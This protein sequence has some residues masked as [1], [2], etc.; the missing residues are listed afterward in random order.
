MSSNGLPKRRVVTR[1]A[2]RKGWRPLVAMALLLLPLVSASGLWAA[3]TH[4]DVIVRDI[5]SRV[6]KLKEADPETVPM[7][8][9]DFDGTIIKGD[10]SEGLVEDGVVRYRGML[11]AG[12]LAGF[13]QFYK[14]EDGCRQYDQDY[15]RLNE[16]G[17]F[18]AWPLIGQAFAGVKVSEFNKFCARRIR[19]VYHSWYFCSSLS[20]LRKLEAAG[21]ENHIIS[22]SPELFVRNAAETIGLT[23]DR[24][25]GL[26]L[27]I[28]GDILSSR[29][30]YPLTT[31]EGKVEVLRRLVNARPHAVAVAGFGDSYTTDGAFLR[32][33]VRQTLPGDVKGFAMMVNATNAPAEYRGLFTDVKQSEVVGKPFAA[34]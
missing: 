29:I 9:W 10:I 30:E 20:I 32:Y 16:I 24:M 21:V 13:S 28:D 11:H 23:A 7:A 33:I 17:R 6:E 27:A 19:E 8:F 26:A 1:G 31:G 22:G 34:R 5:L 18:I 14:G 15:A 12:V 3:E 25:H 2:V 4:A